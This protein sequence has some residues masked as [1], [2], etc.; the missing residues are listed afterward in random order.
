MGT[1]E[2]ACLELEPVEFIDVQRSLKPFVFNFIYANVSEAA[3]TGENRCK[4]R[5]ARKKFVEGG[6][7]GVDAS[8]TGATHTNRQMEAVQQRVAQEEWVLKVRT[9]IHAEEA[10]RE[11]E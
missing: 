3:S 9:Q 10:D 4:G 7:D 6:S 5:H 1:L 8:A 11:L 2:P